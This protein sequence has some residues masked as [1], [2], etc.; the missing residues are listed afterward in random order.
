MELILSIQRFWRVESVLSALTSIS[1]PSLSV[2][3]FLSLVVVLC[4]HWVYYVCLRFVLTPCFISFF[5]FYYEQVYP[6]F[7]TSESKRTSLTLACRVTAVTAYVKV[8]GSV[9]FFIVFGKVLTTV[10]NIPRDIL[11]VKHIGPYPKRLFFCLSFTMK[12]YCF[13]IQVYT[14]EPQH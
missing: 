13:E 3:L 8:C 9:L 1:I 7:I 4:V 11:Y 6:K 10:A 5:F 12:T 14:D 2:C